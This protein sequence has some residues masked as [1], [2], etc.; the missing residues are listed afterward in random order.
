VR[1]INKTEL[2]ILIT[3]RVIGTAID[4]ARISEEMRRATPELEDTFR[5]S[6]RQPAP[7]SPVP[8]GPPP[9]SSP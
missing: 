9:P 8:P 5:R 3:P 7:V 1:T 4:A 6:P 2:L